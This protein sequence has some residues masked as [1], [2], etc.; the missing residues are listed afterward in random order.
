MSFPHRRRAVTRRQER[1]Q[2][3]GDVEGVN[4]EATALVVIRLSVRT[5]FI[6]QGYKLGS[7]EQSI[8]LEG[9]EVIRQLVAVPL[10]HMLSC[11]WVRALLQPSVD[12]IPDCFD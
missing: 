10:V 11:W 5:K 8:F 6:R 9:L 1:E 3:C 7:R 2:I 12:V 4:V